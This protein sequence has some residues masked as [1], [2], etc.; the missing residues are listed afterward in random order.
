MYWFSIFEEIRKGE[1]I[2]ADFK[3][4]ERFTMMLDGEEVKPKRMWSD[5]RFTDEEVEK[6]SR[7]EEISFDMMSKA[8]KPYVAT[9]KVRKYEYN[10]RDV[11]GFKLN[12]RE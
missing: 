6:L 1:I 5:H 8:G 4:V 9:G 11:V 10:G 2:M 3:D 12:E 7:G